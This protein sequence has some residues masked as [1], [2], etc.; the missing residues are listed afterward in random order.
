MKSALPS[1]VFFVVML[2]MAAVSFA[3]Y[4]ETMDERSPLK[5][6]RKDY[7]LADDGGK[8]N[9]SDV[10]QRAIDEMAAQGGGRIFVPRGTYLISGVWL[11][12]NV[13]IRVEA[14]TVIRPYWP[15]GN[16]VSV[17]LM[18]AKPRGRKPTPEEERAFI[19]NV[20]IRGVGGRFVVDY[21]D[22]PMEQGYS[23]VACRMVR[24]FLIADM[25]ILDNFTPHCGIYLVPTNSSTKDV[26]QWPVSRP[27]R[28][29]IRNCRIFNASPGYGLVQLHGASPFCSRIF[30]PK[31]A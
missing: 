5:D 16:K 24:N 3:Q 27:T 28:G 11:R 19:E 22:R 21:S 2:K 25:D 13:H 4:V 10:F 20:S 7:G 26:S 23:A 31:A 1:L 29:T 8:A 14:G 30:T 6:L 18:D 9:Q 12:S 17:F 15:G